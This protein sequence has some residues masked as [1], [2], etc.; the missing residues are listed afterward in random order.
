VQYNGASGA[1]IANLRFRYNPREGNDLYIVY[2]DALNTDRF[3]EIPTLPYTDSRTI[4]LKYSY[5]FNV[6]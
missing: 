6:K 3:S 1:V 2:N 5:T 4:L